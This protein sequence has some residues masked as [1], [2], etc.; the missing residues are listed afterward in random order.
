MKARQTRKTG[1][2]PA[3]ARETRSQ[4]PRRASGQNTASREINESGATQPESLPLPSPEREPRAAGSRIGFLIHD[5]SRMR[6]TLYDQAVRPLNLTRS[7]W[8]VLGQLSRQRAPHGVLQTELARALDIGKVTVGG[9]IDRLEER[10]FIERRP[11]IED[12]RAKRVLVTRAGRDV[13]KQ[14]VRLSED[15]NATVFA[16]F[17]DAEMQM[18]ES[19][20]ARMKANIRQELED[21]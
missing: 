19:V 11:D 9:L 6:S 10:G 21:D 16:G 15:L 3:P 4:A 20:L 13:L 7:Q 17:S 14:M 18:T 5:V 12:R 1:I 2:D 8:W